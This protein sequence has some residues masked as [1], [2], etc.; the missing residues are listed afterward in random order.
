MRVQTDLKA[1]TDSC[2]KC[3]TEIS[4]EMEFE[5]DFDLILGPRKRHSGC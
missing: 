1:G 4:F 2:Y 3:G 5:F